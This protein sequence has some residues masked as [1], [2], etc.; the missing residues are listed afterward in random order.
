M[1]LRYSVAYK[2]KLWLKW[3]KII[4]EGNG[5][6]TLKNP[7]FYGPVLDDCESLEEQGYIL[8]DLTKHFIL[9]IPTPYEVK[10]SWNKK[11]SQDKK[12]VKF[13]KITLQDGE[14]GRL[15]LLKNKD[16]ILINC[17]DHTT[18]QMDKGNFKLRFQAIAYNEH[19]EPYDLLSK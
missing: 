6:I 1:S 17:K 14:L 9:H 16:K 5:K 11:L 19:D 10:L 3:E 18:E 13:D 12:S 7:E 8:L 2:D 15:K 4:H